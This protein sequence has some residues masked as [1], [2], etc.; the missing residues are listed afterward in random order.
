MTDLMTEFFETHQYLDDAP[1]ADPGDE[2]DELEDRELGG[3]GSGNF[4]HVGQG[5]GEVGGS[6]KSWYVL[7]GEWHRNPEDGSQPYGWRSVPDDYEPPEPQHKVVRENG[8]WGY[9]HSGSQEIRSA[10][11]AMM[12]IK[13]RTTSDLKN[14]AAERFLTEIANDDIGSE[15]VLYHAFE[16][17]RHT[18]FSVGDTLRLPLSASSGKSETGYATRSNVEDQKG[19]PVVFRFDKGTQMVA[20]SSSANM[21]AVRDG[22]IDSLYAGR[23]ESGHIWSEAIVAGGFKVT[24]VERHYMTSQMRNNQLKEGEPVPQLFGKIVHLKQIETFVPGTGWKRRG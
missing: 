22:D 7:G 21:K 11:V 5:N 2:T 9:S 16:N 1:D 14:R 3:A 8:A 19:E 10:S 23:K 12:G 20:Y 15:E 18:K 4:G 6:G 17:T 24:K 13:D